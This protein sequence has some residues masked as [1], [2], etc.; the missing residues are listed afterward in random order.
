MTDNPHRHPTRIRTFA[1]DLE[2]KRKGPEV[3]GTTST[4]AVVPVEKKK[5]EPVPLAA[6][7]KSFKTVVPQKEEPA[8]VVP[9]PKP[10]P[11]PE[12]P[13]STEPT[14]IPSFHELQKNVAIIQENI[15]AETVRSA[16]SAHKRKTPKESKPER[17]RPNIGYDA[18]VITDKQVSSFKL[19]PAVISSI[20]EWFKKHKKKRE[21]K[22]TVTE[23]ERRK[24]VIQR[25]ATKTGTIFTADNET[26]RE[27]IRRRR[28]QIHSRTSDGVT[29]TIWS[30]FTETGYTLLEAPDEVQN[31][32]VAYK[33]PRPIE[34]VAQPITVAK[35]APLAPAEIVTSASAPA[36]VETQINDERWEDSHVEEAIP[37]AVSFPEEPV[38]LATEED[39]EP[40]PPE[41]P[42]EYVPPG[43]QSIFTALDTNTMTVM[44]L[45]T[46][47]AVVA[48]VFISRM[49][50]IKYTETSPDTAPVQ[51]Q[52]EPIFSTAEL[53]AIPLTVETLDAIPQLLARSVASSSNSLVE[54]IIV[55]SIG[56]EVSASYLFELLDFRT[57]PSLRQSLLAT[58]FATIQH[59]EPAIILTFTDTD[60]VHGGLLA[61]EA[62]MTDDLRALYAIPTEVTTAF[63]DETIAGKDV[64]V[65]RQNGD[66]VLL[67]SMVTRNLAIITTDSESFTHLV[68]LG[69]NR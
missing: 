53:V 59:S 61:W 11:E 40:L 9:V 42:T 63:V 39:T 34:P 7:P 25:A 27:Q 30:P 35:P 23:T 10:L 37:L 2:E 36:S 43:K 28:S 8:V 29:E 13:S 12:K 50:Y 47:I 19:F 20:K 15:S 52:S 60:T 21:P 32:V 22:Y 18:T 54:Y 5:L 46:I 65:L 24:G 26:L 41:E 31:V 38:A 4:P 57:I 17:V 44:L 1:A 62:T 48:M 58:R 16:H 3:P 51:I 64:R 69:L 6:T 33:R 14:K 66:V 45:L 55:S 67:Y 49:L 56:D 68:E